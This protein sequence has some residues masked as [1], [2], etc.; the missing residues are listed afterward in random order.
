M[1]A[2]FLCQKRVR[3]SALLLGGVSLLPGFAAAAEAGGETQP[4]SETE[5][6]VITGSRI[7]LAAMQSAQDVRIYE[8]PRIE[9]SGQSTITDFLNSLPEVSLSSVE[10]SNIG[11][12]VRLRGAARGSALILINGKRTQSATGGNVSNGFFDLN[13]IPLAMVERIEILPTGSSAIYGGDA[14]SGVVNIIL[15]SGFNGFEA[16]AGYQFADNTE[17]QL[18]SAAAGWKRN[19]FSVSI[20]GSYSNRTALNGRDRAITASP[21]Y[22]PFGGP[23]LGSNLFGL[24]ANVSSVSGNLPGLNSSFASVPVGSSGI[25]LTPANFAA[26]AG[27]QTTGSFTQYQDAIPASPRGGV[28][29]SASYRFSSEFEV[30]TEILWTAYKDKVVFT[31]P[32]LQLTNVPA[33]NPFN[34]FGATVRVSGVVQGAERLAKLSFNEDL[35][36]PVVGA[37]G[38]LGDWSYELTALTSRDRGE[39]VTT[40]QPNNALL[41]AALASSNAAT[42]LNPFID[43]PWAS[44]NLLGSIYST[45]SVT[46]FKV[47]SNIVNGF[48]RGPLLDLPGGT[49]DAVAGGEYEDDTLARG[50]NDTRNAKAAFA[51]LRAP[52]GAIDDGRGGSREL[53]TLDGAVRYDDYSDFGAQTTWQAGLEFRPVESLLLRATHAT[54]FKPPT[55]F[56]LGQ[57]RTSVQSAVFDPKLNNQQVVVTLTSGGNPNLSPTT[58]MSTTAGLV[59]SPR[60]SHN[61]NLTVT[62]WWLRIDNAISVPNA[63]F[64]VANDNLYPGRVVRAAAPP[65][66]V[67]QLVSVDAS[68]INFGTMRESGVDAG[69][70]WTFATGFGDVT[71]AIAATY[72]TEYK[73]ASTPGAP[74]IN[75]LSRAN[76]DLNFAPRW[77][78]T[79]SIAWTPDAPYKL[80]FAGRYVGRYTDFT[81]PRQL[82]DFWYFDA[83]LEVDVVRALNLNEPLLS[84]LKLLVSAT[85]LG[86]KLP[87]FSTYFRGFDP[88]NYDL[89]G[90]TIFVRLQLQT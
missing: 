64:V 8:L 54:A 13:T 67:G 38:N 84:G 28:F 25:G 16:D 80:W 43:G 48:V 57:P 12:T 75:R 2:P 58:G 17:Q 76:N 5:Q 3:L 78:G 50:F 31:P 30:F 40:G 33:S 70:D 44:A 36:R 14:L 71:P 15:K 27:H 6:V 59:W 61:F 42:A 37:R 74:I 83:S 56:N 29:G 68:F 26:T 60:D 85:N 73:G 55:L 20:M 51:E 11:T 82:G 18:Y 32:F 63:Q 69:V 24:P 89:V 4:A 45:T 62:P 72:M 90:R 52:L 49:L 87:P 10:S 34:P 23:N 41:T 81:P 53:L 46:S 1:V 47:H 22:R 19:D 65:G 66:Q 9:Q 86:N 39:S 79:A 7:P 21:D 35:V 77:K 88:S